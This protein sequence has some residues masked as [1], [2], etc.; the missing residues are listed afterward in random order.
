MEK[1]CIKVQDREILDKLRGLRSLS[2]ICSLYQVEEI[3]DS[4]HFIST[5]LAS[6]RHIICTAVGYTGFLVD[7]SKLQ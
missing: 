1:R 6:P 3:I 7:I 2:Y 4:M 5:L